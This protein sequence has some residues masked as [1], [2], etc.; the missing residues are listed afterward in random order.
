[1]VKLGQGSSLMAAGT[2][3]SSTSW[4]A[5]CNDQSQHRQLTVYMGVR[6]FKALN[7]SVQIED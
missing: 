7:G 4:T 2:T 5:D 1:M 6:K 3:G